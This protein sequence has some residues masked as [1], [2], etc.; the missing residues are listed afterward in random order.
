MSVRSN[1]GLY[2]DQAQRLCWP[3]RYSDRLV[4]CR[5][6]G[7]RSLKQELNFH[8]LERKENSSAFRSIEHSS[9]Q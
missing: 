2:I 5:T 8:G 6:A 7:L 1:A 4:A 3:D 9:V